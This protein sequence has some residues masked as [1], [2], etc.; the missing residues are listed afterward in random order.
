M[1]GYGK[2]AG[3][4]ALVAG[5]K[6]WGTGARHGSTGVSAPKPSI[7][8]HHIATSEPLPLHRTWPCLLEPKA[9]SAPATVTAMEWSPPAAMA[10]TRAGGFSFMGSSDRMAWGKGMDSGCGLGPCSSRREGRQG[11]R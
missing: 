7:Q 5:Q 10:V 2:R 1:K 8:T 11:E 4:A 3:S 9:S 6:Q